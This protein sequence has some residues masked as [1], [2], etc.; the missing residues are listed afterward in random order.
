MQG[1]SAQYPLITLPTP[2][3]LKEESLYVVRK[4]LYTQQQRL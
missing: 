2:T 1:G 3:A 4:F